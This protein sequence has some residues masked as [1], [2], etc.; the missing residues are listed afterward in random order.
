M[1]RIWN[2]D[3]FKLPRSFKLFDPCQFS[4]EAK[5]VVASDDKMG[6]KV[7]TYRSLKRRDAAGEAW[8]RL[9]RDSRSVEKV[10]SEQVVRV[11][12]IQMHQ[13]RLGILAEAF[14]RYFILFIQDVAVGA[15]LVQ[16]M[17]WESGWR[18]GKYGAA[19][20]QLCHSTCLF[21]IEV[22]QRR[23]LPDFGHQ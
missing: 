4:F 21:G 12:D 6:S 22:F 17:G 20:S 10:G 9:L 1:D 3:W 19:E 8:S 23:K 14:L 15:W 11:P 16:W 18:T 7:S 5:C 2:L 13:T